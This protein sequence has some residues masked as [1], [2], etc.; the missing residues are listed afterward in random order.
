MA[1]RRGFIGGATGIGTAALIGYST[2]PSAAAA[3]ATAT[4]THPQAWLYAKLSHRSKSGLA[5]GTWGWVRDGFAV[6]R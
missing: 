3:D 6:S 4:V 1:T 5:S 2:A